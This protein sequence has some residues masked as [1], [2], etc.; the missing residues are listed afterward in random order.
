LITTNPYN[1]KEMLDSFIAGSE[2]AFAAIYERYAP[3]LIN[4][5]ASRTDSLEV[6]KDII[7]DIFVYLWEEKSSIQINSSLE[8]YLFA[9]AR[10]R[11][12]DH[13]RHNTTH[14]KYISKLRLLTPTE[15][16]SIENK[17]AAKELEKRI[18]NAID[19]LSP[20]VKE[21]YTLSR[22]NHLSV[23]EIATLLNL[24]PQTVKNQLTSALSF[25]RS[26]LTKLKIL[27]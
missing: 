12:I 11:L 8:A 15:N 21:V 2:R 14:Q 27:F 13:F 16:E 22:I 17:L 5:V 6:A 24:K 26:Q 3:S 19:E 7:H 1:E 4:F 20:R 9:S 25:L 10:Y 18:V 23:S